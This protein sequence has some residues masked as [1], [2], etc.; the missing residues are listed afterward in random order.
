MWFHRF[1]LLLR[2]LLVCSLLAV[3]IAPE[4][5]QFGSERYQVNQIVADRSFDFLVWELNAIEVKVKSLLAGGPRYL[6]EEQRQE[7]VLA[8]LDLIQRA[9]NLE[10]NIQRLYSDPEVTD[11]A[12]ATADLQAELAEI[13]QAISRRKGL[14][15]AIVQEQVSDILVEEG[16]GLLGQ[17]WPPVWMHMTP[18]PLLLVLSPRDRIE[19]AY[20]FSLE[21]GLSIAVIEEME[22]AVE[23]QIDYSALVVPIG[24]MATYP[25]MIME[26]SSLNWLI[27]VTVHEWAH[28]WLTFFPLGWYYGDPQVRT[29]NETV[30][31][32]VDEEFRDLVL[33]RYY[34]EA[35]ISPSPPLPLPDPDTPATEPEPPIF[36]FR[37]EMA[38][39]RVR[40]DE[41]LAAD[42]IETAEAYMEE[43][44]L[45]FLENGYRIRKL[46][47]AYFAFYGAY[48]ARPGGATG[49]DPIGPM[50]RD[51]RAHS[52]SL[53]IFMEQ[54]APIDSFEKLV[55]V[56]EA[57]VEE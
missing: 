23:D 27:E 31:S 7:I 54:V 12:Q 2:F 30:A 42:E 14:A 34:P 28:H 53:R 6:S 55:E 17:A 35:Y 9:N 47:Q 11:P 1:K 57:V 18:L 3:L 13:R 56:W 32:L 40:V 26:T 4:W 39:T 48:A 45:F 21:H 5:P 33:L 8:Y 43:R 29:I 50:L 24:G 49:D 38:E 36:D 41:L 37:A 22:T 51:I 16:F 44:R 19:R 52:P 10:A 20:A 25:A 46:N 15:E